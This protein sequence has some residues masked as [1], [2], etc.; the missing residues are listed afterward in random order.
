MNWKLIVQLSVFG[1]IMAIATISLIPQ[2]FEPAFW[3][4]TFLFCAYTIAKV[5]AG[6]YFLHGFLVSLANCVWIT[7]VHL[8]FYNSYIEHHPAMAEMNAT[9]PAPYLFH[10]RLIMLVTGPVFGIISGLILGLFAFVASKI[11]KK[12]T[13]AIQ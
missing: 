11:V 13:P 3:L 7:G 9:L 10:P 6:R 8:I 2:T 5:C 1:L 12:P 4:V